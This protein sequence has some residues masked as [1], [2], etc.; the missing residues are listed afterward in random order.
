MMR[1]R[2]RPAIL[3]LVHLSAIEQ[4]VRLRGLRTIRPVFIFPAQGLF[5]HFYLTAVRIEAMQEPS[6]MRI[7]RTQILE[8][9]APAGFSALPG[10]TRRGIA[11][12]RPC[13]RQRQ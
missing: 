13:K 7:E 2:C 6:T 8:M 4:G 5:V 12:H 3:M 11:N 10:D 9:T 1:L